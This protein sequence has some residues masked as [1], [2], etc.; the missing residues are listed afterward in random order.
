MVARSVICGGGGWWMGR[1]EWRGVAMLGPWRRGK[2]DKKK[3][4]PAP[5]ANRIEGWR[6]FRWGGAVLVDLG[7]Q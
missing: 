7:A 2:K 4:A 6:C 1:G 5:E 3:E